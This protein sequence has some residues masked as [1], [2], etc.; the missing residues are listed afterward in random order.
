MKK[1]TRE[2]VFCFWDNCISTGIP[3]LT[4]LRTGYLSFAANILENSPKIWHIS[5]RYIFQLHSLAVITKYD[6]AAVVQFSIVFGSV[7]HVAS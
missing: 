7:Y 3:K 2:K 6:K 5:K 1:K 4:L